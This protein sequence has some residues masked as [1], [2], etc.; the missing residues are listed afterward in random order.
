M[1]FKEDWQSS[2]YDQYLID[3]SINSKIF[4]QMAKGEVKFLCE[5]LKI[6][7]HTK[8][9]DIPCG[10]GRHTRLLARKGAQVTGVDLNPKCLELAAQNCRGLKLHLGQ[11]NMSDLGKYYD[12][13]DIVLNL[14]TSFGY[15]STE[16]K[17]K[18]IL[19]EFIKCLRPGGLLVI[20]FICQFWFLKNFSKNSVIE[21]EYRVQKETRFF[22]HNTK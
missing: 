18:K 10:T 17:N 19:L 6:T 21:D 9:L 2:L 20:H 5:T 8:I 4:H 12:Q 15:F 11:S 14:F 22:D 7:S 3:S 16:L 1:N 13:F